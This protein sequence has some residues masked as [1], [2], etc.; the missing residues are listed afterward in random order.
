[1]SLHSPRFHSP[2]SGVPRGSVQLKRGREWLVRNQ[3]KTGYWLTYSLNK[4]R[5]LSSNVGRFMSDAATAYAV[6]ALTN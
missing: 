2:G 1:M 5:D 3:D 6:P 4:R